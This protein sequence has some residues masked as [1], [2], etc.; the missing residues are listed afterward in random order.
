MP[1]VP[2]WLTG[3]HVT[4]CSITP[5]TVAANGT[6]TAGTSSSL[7]GTLDEITLDSTPELEEIS[8][9]DTLFQNN[10]ILKNATRITLTQILKSNGTNL[11]TAAA[12]AADVFAVVITRGGQTWT[13]YGTRGAYSEGLR[14]GR[15]TCSLTLEMI[16]ITTA[17][18][19]Y[20]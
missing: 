3:R 5:Q 18:P 10:V 14:R 1:S 11:L 13:F 15:S 19:T 4:T 17:N 16:D 2:T 8:P 12:N 6:L 20:V 7:V 9:M